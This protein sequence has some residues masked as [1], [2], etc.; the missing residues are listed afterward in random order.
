MKKPG[1]YVHIPFCRSK[2]P[3]CGFYSIAS[4]S[5]VPAWL[6]AL[7][8]EAA[9]YGD[10]FEGFD[11]LYLGGGTPSVLEL[12]VLQRVME[13]L[14]DRFRFATD[15]EITLEANP[16]DLS[17]DKI[18][19]IRQLGF[20]RISVGV[21]SFDDRTLALLG[22][23]HTVRQAEQALADLFYAGFE[24][25]GMDLI[26]GVKGQG[27]KDWVATLRHALTFQPGHL[28]CYQLSLEPKTP[29]AR[30]RNQGLIR[31]LEEKQ[32]KDF[33]LA[34]SRLLEASGY[35]HYEIS[36][37]AKTEAYLSRHNRKYWNHTPYLGLGPSAHSFF[38]GI[39]W[40][41]FRSVRKYAE[42]L[43]EGKMPIEGYELLTAKQ[44]RLELLALGLRTRYGVNVEEVDQDPQT[45][46]TLSMLEKSGF[47]TLQNGRAS[48]TRKGFL[49]ADALPLY[50]S[51]HR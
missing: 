43:K 9:F 32:E 34:T 1:L 44:L 46:R 35:I 23:G 33:F 4:T 25:V 6:L 27:L 19:G 28:S 50:F 30:L 18:R 14:F 40:W 51:D 10:L 24:N 16:Q 13:I 45:H 3:Y 37:F 49:V 39:R 11:T 21:Q 41:N 48:P 12:S 36:N 2:C 5:L 26:Y 47:L 42:D 8:R 20:N 29:F 7:E 17:P 31:P 22:R 38:E 15:S